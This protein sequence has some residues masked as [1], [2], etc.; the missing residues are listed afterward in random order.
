MGGTVCRIRAPPSLQVSP[1]C[2]S[3]CAGSSADFDV[4][5]SGH[6][7]HAAA[8]VAAVAMTTTTRAL[9]LQRDVICTL[10]KM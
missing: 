6:H 10:V 8:A 3:T 5:M 9:H 1:S 4:R 7:R 2:G